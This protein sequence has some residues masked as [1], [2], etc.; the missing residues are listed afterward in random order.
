MVYLHS[1]FKTQ[2]F[3]NQNEQLLRKTYTML[4]NKTKKYPLP[5]KKE[6][7][8]IKKNKKNQKK[9]CQNTKD[10]K[11]LKCENETHKPAPLATKSLEEQTGKTV[12]Y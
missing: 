9:Q 8:K 10:I 6:I 11:H 2:L 7:Q 5:P 1:S 3:I 4:R 12:V